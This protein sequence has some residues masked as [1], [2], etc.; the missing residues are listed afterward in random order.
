MS[1]EGWEL[2]HVSFGKAPGFILG[3]TLQSADLL[4]SIQV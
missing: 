4:V 1:D 3:T 2:E